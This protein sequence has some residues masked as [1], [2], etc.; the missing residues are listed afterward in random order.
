MPGGR[1]LPV[2]EGHDAITPRL[3]REERSDS[4]F[5]TASSRPP[6]FKRKNIIR[7]VCVF[8][9]FTE[10]CERLCFYGL[11]GSLKTFL[12]QRLG[13]PL[14]QSNALAAAFPAIVYVTPLLGGYVADVH[15]GRYKTI[16]TFA[17]IYILG[18]VLMATASYPAFEN[19]QLFMFALLLSHLF[20]S[21]KMVGEAAH[22]RIVEKTL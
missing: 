21:N 6:S 4:L 13:F 3:Q 11:S 9:L 15:L 7:D 18:T 17:G 16:V 19:R 2:F 1:K 20:D 12:N 5:S 22:V 10:C 14:S 8:I